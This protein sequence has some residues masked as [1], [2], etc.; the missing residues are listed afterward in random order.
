MTDDVDLTGFSD[1]IDRWII[2]ILKGIGCDTAG[3]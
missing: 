1:E 3:R 2:D